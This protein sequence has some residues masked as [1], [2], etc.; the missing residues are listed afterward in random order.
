MALVDKSLVRRSGERFWQLE[1]IRDF[2]TEQLLSSGE[3]QQ[4]RR[5]HA[6]FFLRLAAEA[7]QGLRS[8]SAGSWLDRLDQEV[9]NIRSAVDF[10]RES[11]DATGMLLLATRLPSFWSA[12]DLSEGIGWLD[13][14]LETGAGT[15]AERGAGF[16][17]AAGLAGNLGNNERKLEL[18]RQ[19]FDAAGRANDEATLAAA[20]G[21]YGWTL[22]E[23][24]DRNGAIEMMR[25]SRALA[26][27]IE[28][29]SARAEVQR[30][31]AAI[32]ALTGDL[33]EA[34]RL[35][36]IV[37]GTYQELG[38][39]IGVAYVLNGM[40]YKAL[41]GGNYDEAVAML[42][43]SLEIAR[44]LRLSFAT[45]QLNNLGLIAVFQGRFTDA[46]APFGEALERTAATGD[47]RTGAEAV[48]GLAATH[49]AL[50][51]HDLARTLEAV[52]KAEY[53]ATGL[54]EAP[55]VLDR[56]EP[57]LHA[58]RQAGD[59]TRIKALT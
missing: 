44:R 21:Q 37:L 32:L 19:A 30:F 45:A 49:A 54:V 20:F 9:P 27:T 2:A 58:A 51:N 29:P 12:R 34:A 26:S 50:G 11:G 1:T 46:L 14:A 22:A 41:L 15:P 13:E 57:H 23:M 24:G 47:R 3:A 52:A 35:D 17:A 42:E 56:L 55:E 10:L 31:V 7:R 16:L 40:G 36:R 39:E 6:D 18:L 38:D 25:R 8:S 43:E 33:D 4:V 53:K 5:R 48:L 28:D 59:E